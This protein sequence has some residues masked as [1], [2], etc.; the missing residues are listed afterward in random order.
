MRAGVHGLGSCA[1]DSIIPFTDTLTSVRFRYKINGTKFY[2]YKM[3][4]KLLPM[5]EKY[6]V[7]IVFAGHVHAYERTYPVWNG[8][9]VWG[10]SVENFTITDLAGQ[11]AGDPGITYINVG[12]GGNWHGHCTN[13]WNDRPWSAFHSNDTFGHGVLEMDDDKTARWL[14]RTI[15]ERNM[16][17]YGNITDSVTIHNYAV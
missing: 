11:R 4:E 15:P 1:S 16:L 5:L 7:N 6:K 2:S 13:V 14:W 3:N 17:G 12:A 10:P 9:E 8:S